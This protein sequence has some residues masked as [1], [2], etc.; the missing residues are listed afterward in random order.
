MISVDV[1]ARGGIVVIEALVCTRQ[2][3]PQFSLRPYSRPGEGPIDLPFLIDY[4]DAERLLPILVRK[5]A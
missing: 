5:A 1:C 4:L 2:R 3:S